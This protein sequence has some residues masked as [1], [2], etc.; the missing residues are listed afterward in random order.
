M[1]I[2]NTDHF[3]LVIFSE[4]IWIVGSSIIHWAQKYAADNMNQN[5]RLFSHELVWKGVRGMVWDQIYPTIKSLLQKYKSPAF[6]ILHCGGN[7]IGNP[8][9]T[10]LGTQKYMKYIVVKLHEL[11]PKTV[12]VWS[13]ILPRRNW[14]HSLSNSEGEKC[15]RRINSSLATFVLKMGG[16]SIKYPDIV[17][18]HKSLF[19]SDGVHL[20]DLGNSIFVNSL[21]NAIGQFTETSDMLYP[22]V[23]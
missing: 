11:L 12:I 14:I 1:N 5:L 23:L 22:S 8:Y 19:R 4:C 10:L 16:A 3:Q 17:D 15:R 6:L 18:S 21:K 20:S 7:D 13:H 9:S 2:S